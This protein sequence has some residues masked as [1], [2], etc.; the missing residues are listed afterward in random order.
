M[1]RSRKTKNSVDLG[2]EETLWRAADKLRGNLDAV[3]YMHPVL[4][5]FVEAPARTP[6]R[7]IPPTPSAGGRE[8]AIAALASASGR[9][10]PLEPF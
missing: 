7:P 8:L 5:I 6:D 4:G 9:W 10:L 2:F 3:E 1:P